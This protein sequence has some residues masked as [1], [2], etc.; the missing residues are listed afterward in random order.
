MKDDDSRD[1]FSTDTKP[2]H[3]EIPGYIAP[4]NTC[5][6]EMP[7]SDGDAVAVGD[8][9]SGDARRAVRRDGG[10]VH[11]EIRSIDEAIDALDDHLIDLRER[12]EAIEAMDRRVEALTEMVED[13]YR[14][15][16]DVEARTEGLENEFVPPSRIEA[17]IEEL[18]GYGGADDAEAVTGPCADGVDELIDLGDTAGGPSE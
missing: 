13:V 5:G 10:D 7:E 18:T 9:I 8:L 4:P 12:V 16:D 11:Q 2:G 3:G 14:R 17:A 1:S 6:I 15:M